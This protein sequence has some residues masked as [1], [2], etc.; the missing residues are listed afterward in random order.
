MVDT[1]THATQQHNTA[2]EQ[3][4]NGGSKNRDRKSKA[5]LGTQATLENKTQSAKKTQA[6]PRNATNHD[7]KGKHVKI[8]NNS[9]GQKQK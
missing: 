6:M 2:A 5:R 7:A 4:D 3:S 8:K 9:E 1:R